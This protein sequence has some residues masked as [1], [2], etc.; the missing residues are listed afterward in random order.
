[1]HPR[2]SIRV[3]KRS[4]SFADFVA[5]MLGRE[6]EAF[7]GGGLELG[8]VRTSSSLGLGLGGAFKPLVALNPRR[9]ISGQARQRLQVTPAASAANGPKSR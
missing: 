1:V 7:G 9:T 4:S 2:R 6:L 3:T 5:P 8:R